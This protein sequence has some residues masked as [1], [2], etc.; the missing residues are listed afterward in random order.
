M[1]GMGQEKCIQC[2]MSDEPDSE[3][4][5]EIL[6]DLPCKRPLSFYRVKKSPVKKTKKK[7]AKKVAKKVKKIPFDID[8]AL[9]QSRALQE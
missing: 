1:Q 8:K 4:I 7:A 6:N 9:E 3:W 2:D 5:D